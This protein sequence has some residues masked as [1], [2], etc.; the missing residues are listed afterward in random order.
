MVH[1]FIYCK[2]KGQTTVHCSVLTL[3]MELHV[4][5]KPVIAARF[6]ATLRTSV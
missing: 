3:S 5:C 4:M 6:E 2:E 1:I